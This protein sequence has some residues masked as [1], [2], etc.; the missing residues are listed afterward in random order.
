MLFCVRRRFFLLFCFSTD[1]AMMKKTGFN[2]SG[3][4]LFACHFSVFS[5]DWGAVMP[6]CKFHLVLIKRPAIIPKRGIQHVHGN[7]IQICLSLFKRSVH[8]P[9]QLLY[10]HVS[11]P[12]NSTSPLTPNHSTTHSPSQNST[13]PSTTL[14]PKYPRNSLLPRSLPTTST[15]ALSDGTMSLR[16]FVACCERA[17]GG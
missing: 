14:S 2:F 15:S 10:S 7:P 6:S 5:G 1:K 3:T 9:S 16:T 4:C 13:T 8:E 17:W 11:S 12:P